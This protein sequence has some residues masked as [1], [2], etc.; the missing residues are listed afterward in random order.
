ELSF[1]PV[2]NVRANLSML[3]APA[4]YYSLSFSRHGEPLAPL[5]ARVHRVV[6]PAY[7]VLFGAGLAW[8]LI[9]RDRKALLFVVAPTLMVLAFI[10]PSDGMWRFHL[11]GPLLAPLAAGQIGPPPPPL[12]PSL[13]LLAPFPPVL[14]PPPPPPP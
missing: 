12:P 13:L 3:A 14:P 1:H 9:R 5:L 10:Q 2:T 7:L 6:T 11:L 4:I 8:A